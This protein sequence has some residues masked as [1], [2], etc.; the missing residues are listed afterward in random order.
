MKLI[1]V[2]HPESTGNVTAQLGEGPVWD[3]ALGQLYWIDILGRQIH[4]ADANGQTHTSTELPRMP[5]TLMPAAGGGFL[6]ADEH[7]LEFHSA[8]GRVVVVDSALA[9]SPTLRFNDGKVDPAGRVVV[10]TLALDGAEAAATLFRLD[11]VQSLSPLVEGVT[12]SN[13][14]GWS[15]DGTTLYYV[16]TPTGRVDA[17]DYDTQW[18][19]VSH[20]RM[21]AEIPKGHG[22]PDGLCVDDDGGVWVALYGGSAVLRFDPSGRLDTQVDFDIPHITSCAFGGPDGNVLFVTTAKVGLSEDFLAA[23]PHAG[24]LFTV[25][26]G[27]T[28][29]PANLWRPQPLTD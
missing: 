4:V 12:L 8:D 16:D 11:R 26:T 24:G 3:A 18:G 27:R 19:A 9:D 15:P 1:Q 28:G 17:F 10:G 14:L 20:R 21:F 7:G 2:L 29:P 6:L 23:H 13:G 22:L 5:G 25:A